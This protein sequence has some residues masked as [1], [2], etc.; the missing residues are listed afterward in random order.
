MSN[1]ANSAT[2]RSPKKQKQTP[3]T[4]NQ[5]GGSAF[6]LSDQL[7]LVTL[8]ATSFCQNQYYTSANDQ[9]KRITELGAKVDPLFA[10]KL[11][12]YARDQLNMRS[13]THVLAATVG[14]TA[15]GQIWTKSFFDKVVLRPDDMIE[16]I[17]FFKSHFGKSIPSAMKKGFAKAFGRMDEYKLRKYR[18]NGA[19]TLV[20]VARLCHPKGGKDSPVGK[21]I[22]DKLPLA[23][24]WETK[25]SAAGSNA[26]A[27]TEAFGSLIREEKMGYMALLRNMRNILKTGDEEVITL[28]CAQLM[29]PPRIKKSRLLPFRFYSAYKELSKEDNSRQVLTA[30]STACDFSL[31]NLAAQFEGNTLI[32]VDTSGSM[33]SPVAKGDMSCQEAGMLF[34]S[35]VYRAIPNS[36]IMIWADGAAMVNMPDNIPLIPMVES[37]NSRANGQV[38]HGTNV[39]AV[40]Q[41]AGKKKYDRIV[42]MSDMQSYLHNGNTALNAYKTRTKSDPW[43]H[44]FDLRGCGN[45][46]LPWDG[47]KV[48][49]IPGFSDKV[50]DILAY[51]ENDPQAMI[52]EIGK[53]EL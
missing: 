24:T 2:V 31:D 36:D 25:V 19:I 47:K 50:L 14:A 41:G 48:S 38:G 23:E 28:A 32:A 5:A 7:Q 21:L 49:F 37:I 9:I 35:A 20:D 3:N 34:G 4:V 53:I 18:G 52:T 12:V 44:W 10:A 22:Y 39:D 46:V 1:F 15:K 8:L 27:K 42:I 45:T 51:A 11:A 29:S 13:A 26:E 33:G 16:I 6:K 30:I 17:A 40:F 43:I